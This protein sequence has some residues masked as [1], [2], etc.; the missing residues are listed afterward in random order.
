MAGDLI[1]T[2]KLRSRA[3]H[4]SRHRQ[5]GQTARDI[6][7]LA[8]RATHSERMASPVPT[9]GYTGDRVGLAGPRVLPEMTWPKPSSRVANTLDRSGHTLRNGT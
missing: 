7:C 9:A 1:A 3:R 4:R 8:A 6:A 2:G 5:H